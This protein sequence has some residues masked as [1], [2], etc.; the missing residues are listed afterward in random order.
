MPPTQRNTEDVNKDVPTT[1][2]TTGGTGARVAA[3][4]A[5][6]QDKMQTEPNPELQAKLTDPD[7]DP[8]ERHIPDES[9][10][11]PRDLRSAEAPGIRTEAEVIAAHQADIDRAVAL[12]SRGGTA[13]PA[14]STSAVKF[15]SVVNRERLVYFKRADGHVDAVNE[16]TPE[17]GIL[18][19]DP[20]V[21]IVSK[22]DADSYAKANA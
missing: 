18:L 1:T 5:P 6:K 2:D 14:I 13:D 20:D 3:K 16:G 10:P 22:S 9:V 7:Q 15:P 12:A 8:T 19:G 4:G 11:L 21:E 17:H